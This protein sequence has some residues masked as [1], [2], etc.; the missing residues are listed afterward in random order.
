MRFYYIRG[1][2]MKKDYNEF[3][4]KNL[5]YNPKVL[6]LI[7]GTGITIATTS[8]FTL[9]PIAKTEIKVVEEYD[10]T[11]D[12]MAIEKMSA[13]TNK[14]FQ[15]MTEKKEYSGMKL[16]SKSE[17]EIKH[18]AALYNVPYQIVLTIGE[19]ESS[20]MWNNNGVISSTNDYGR[21]QINEYN[22]PYIE[23]NLGYNKEEILNDPIKN[24]EACVF[25]LRNIIN[26][27]DVNSVEQVFGMYNGW[28]GWKDKPLAVDYS[29]T[30]C[31]IMN[32]YFPD[33][34]YEKKQKTN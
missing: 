34:E 33:F 14:Q 27:E 26:R 9:N 6:A 11:N 8:I 13:I 19:R 24:T 31:E 23:E 10:I 21:F 30:C 17:D 18:I 16:S 25:L 2:N 4:I 5:C 28:V 32:N 15:T 20:G 3:K 29:N 7:V 22:L 12:D 1:D